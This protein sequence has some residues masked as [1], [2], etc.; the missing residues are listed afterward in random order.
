MDGVVGLLSRLMGYRYIPRSL[1]Q[2]GIQVEG[3]RWQNYLEDV[4]SRSSN[5]FVTAKTDGLHA[6]LLV[7]PTFSIIVHGTAVKITGTMGDTTAPLLLLEGEFLEKFHVFDVLY[8]RKPLRDKLFSQRLTALKD[9]DVQAL[10]NGRKE[11]KGLVQLKEFIRLAE[12]GFNQQIASFYKSIT[13]G[14]IRTDGLI[15]CSDDKYHDMIIYKWK[16]PELLT[17]DFYIKGGKLCCGANAAT[18]KALNLII[19]SGSAADYMP[20]LFRPMICGKKIP[21]LSA[22]DAKKYEG[23][24]VEC[25][26][27]TTKWKVHKER[28]DRALDLQS[29][30]YFGNDH[31][32]AEFT[33]MM[34]LNPLT[35]EHITT[36]PEELAKQVYFRVTNQGD[37]DMV[38]KYNNAVKRALINKY[39]RHANVVDL[40]SGKGQDLLKYIS[41]GVEYLAEVEQDLPAMEECVHRIYSQIKLLADMRPP[42]RID[43]IPMDLMEPHTINRAILSGRVGPDIPINLVVCNFAIHYF[44]LDNIASLV[45]LLLQPA[46][47][48]IC[49]LL[50]RD[51]V[52]AEPHPRISVNSDKESIK[53]KL[54]FSIDYHEEKLVDSVKLVDAF[55]K[56]KMVLHETGG[57]TNSGILSPS[58]L[59]PLSA[60]ERAFAKLYSYYVFRKV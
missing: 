27:A 21:Q 30:K 38:R 1:K 10:V 51:A 36:P 40:A 23:S 52:L 6:F 25:S 55:K 45:G 17:I 49:T 5:F 9:P 35:L 46:G 33:F 58:T 3:L 50:N 26:W 48:F 37:A 13:A 41:A 16:P 32:V 19:A 29:G 56:N 22:K 34:S 54:P 20:V 39:A 43:I 14:K 15:F 47:Y 2:L 18:Q 4:C 24:V 28:K 44:A 7:G 12:K 42:P 59:D 11:L 60:E 8:W 31:R 53:I 57:F